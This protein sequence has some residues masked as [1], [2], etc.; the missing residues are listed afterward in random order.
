MAHPSITGTQPKKINVETGIFESCGTFYF[1]NIEVLSFARLKRYAELL[2]V[3][4]Y[5]RKYMDLALFIHELRVKMTTGEESMKQTHFE[6][7]TA[8]TQWDQYLMDNANNFYDNTIDDMLRFCALLWNEKGE[9][10][11]VIDDIL[12][13]QKIA[14]WK[15]D[16]DVL[17]FFFFAKKQIPRYS[18]L[19]QTLLADQK[20]SKESVQQ[21]EIPIN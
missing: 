12:I 13:E 5:G 3:V 1:L 8:L 4:I 7:A 18:E 21:F 17:G 19:L 16:M 20:K 9:D 14:N 15:K 6:V 11:T 2:P 10:T